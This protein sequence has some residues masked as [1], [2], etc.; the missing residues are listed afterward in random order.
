[1]QG[2]GFVT[3][4]NAAEADRAR[5]KLNGT[6][7]EGRKIE[8]CMVTRRVDTHDAR[9]YVTLARSLVH[10]FVHVYSSTTEILCTHRPSVSR[11]RI[12]VDIHDHH[13]VVNYA[14]VVN[15]AQRVHPVRSVY[16]HPPS[17]VLGWLCVHS[18]ACAVYRSCCRQC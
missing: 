18:P 13:R 9:A 14:R 16:V 7:V 6:V 5:D 2:F 8:V 11:E 15:D 12:N 4:A 3:F 17:S 1:M 10:F